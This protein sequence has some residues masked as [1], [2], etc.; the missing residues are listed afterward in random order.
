M[1]I[2]LTREPLRK[3]TRK[4][5]TLRSNK[6]AP[7]ERSNA[8][9]SYLRCGV[10]VEEILIMIMYCCDFDCKGFFS[11]S[12]NGLTGIFSTPFPQLP[13]SVRL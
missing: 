4:K 11:M 1:V 7:P 6:V 9:T 12:K 3:V 13:P 10:D 5:K 2:N 8:P